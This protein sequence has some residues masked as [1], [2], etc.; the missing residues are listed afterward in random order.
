MQVRSLGGDD[1]LEEEKAVHSSILTWEIQ[2]TEEPGRIPS[3]GLQRIR[4]DLVTKQQSHSSPVQSHF[5]CESEQE[6]ERTFL[7]I[8]LQLAACSIGLPL[9]FSW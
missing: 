3:M 4:H 5:T 8:K 6:Q 7:M 2:W 9:W 1:P